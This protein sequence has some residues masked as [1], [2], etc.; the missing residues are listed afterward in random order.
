MFTHEC[1]HCP[2]KVTTYV[3]DLAGKEIM[4]THI[5]DVHPNMHV[6]KV[7]FVDAITIEDARFLRSCGIAPYL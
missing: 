1:P 3:S 7:A 6:P 2:Y 4:D 5:L